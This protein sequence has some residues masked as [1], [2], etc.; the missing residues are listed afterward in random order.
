VTRWR[1]RRDEREPMALG[2]LI[3][4]N[5]HRD[6]AAKILNHSRWRFDCFLPSLQRLLAAIVVLDGK[7][8]V[9]EFLPDRSVV[10]RDRH[11]PSAQF[12]DGWLI[13]GFFCNRELLAQL[14]N[15]SAAQ[16]VGAAKPESETEYDQPI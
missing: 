13:V 9:R 7:L 10:R 5:L 16:R 4:M 11:N 15:I 2:R 12:D 1:F 14:R 6:V 8:G 3:I